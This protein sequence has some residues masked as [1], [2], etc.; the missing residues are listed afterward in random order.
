MDNF[1]VSVFEDD[2][3]DLIQLVNDNA[4][5]QSNG[6]SNSPGQSNESFLDENV[7]HSDN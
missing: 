5:G 6:D 2:Q 3:V 4:P 1:H 7:S